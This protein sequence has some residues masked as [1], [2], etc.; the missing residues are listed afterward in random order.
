[1]NTDSFALF[2]P[3]QSSIHATLP[4]EA[5]RLDAAAGGAAAPA[6][7]AAGGAA[8]GGGDGPAPPPTTPL[9]GF[10]IVVLAMGMAGVGKTA[11]R[12]SLAHPGTPQ[13]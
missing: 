12:H 11:T 6:A 2:R 9:E 13:L 4:T 10:E 3:P 7:A 1:V 5:A 8:A